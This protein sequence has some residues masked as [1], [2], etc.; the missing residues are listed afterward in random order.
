MSWPGSSRSSSKGESVGRRFGGLGLG[1][2]ISRSIVEQHGGQLSATSG[3]TG[4][5][6]TF[7]VEMPAVAP[8]PVSA[9]VDDALGARRSSPQRPLT[10][11][12][13]EDNADT[14][15]YLSRMLALRGHDIHTADSLVS[16]FRVASEVN[17]D[18]LVSDI[19]LPDG[20]GLELMWTLRS[21]RHAG[22]RPVRIRVIRGHR[23]EPIGRVCRALDQASRLPQAGGSDPASGSRQ[24][25]RRAAREMTSG[26][27]PARGWRPG[28]TPSASSWARED[29]SPSRS[30]THRRRRPALTRRQWLRIS[31][32]GSGAALA[33][34]NS[35]AA[36]PDPCGDDLAVDDATAM[37]FSRE[38]PLVPAAGLNNAR[39]VWS[40]VPGRPDHCVLIYL[41]GH[42]GYV[43]VNAAGRPRVPDWAAGNDTARKGAAA[44]PPAPLEYGLDRLASRQTGKEPIVLVPEDST[45]ATGH[46]WAKEPAGQYA[47]AERLG[48]LVGDC[49]GHLACL[50]RRDGRPYLPADFAGRRGADPVAP[51]SSNLPRT[52][53]D[54]IYLCGHSGAGLPLEE[55]AQSALILPDR[56][57]PADLWLFDCTY[58]SQVAGFIRFCAR[59]KDA[60]RLAGG[61]RDA[62]R[63]VCIY[64]PKTQTEE[65]ADTLRAEIARAIDTDDAAMV[66]N[67]SPANLEKDVR[68]ALRRAGALFVRTHLPHD[69]IP[70]AFIPELLRTAAS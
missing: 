64:R 14:L 27:S 46:F 60:G 11:L 61:R 29:G 51:G 44:K 31:I 5:G 37:L 25:G 45:L 33:G 43:T 65:V 30:T 62:A 35:A 15:N 19:E 12:L 63:F 8:V 4:L 47:D 24:P 58:W 23:A 39:A 10:I 28:V 1:L 59:W 38:A 57:A 16:A 18:V 13:V 3:G 36:E 48:R 26:R 40:H 20:S 22:N 70:T 34:V 67:H 52:T 54:R 9:R 55:A 49:L 32:L 41:H 7:T 21:G 69:E 17:F 50:R 2:T 56:G 53:L 6:A 42:N 66:V 68:P